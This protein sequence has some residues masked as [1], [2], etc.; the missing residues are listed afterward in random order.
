MAPD[1][2]TRTEELD[3]TS[4]F[5]QLIGSES[6]FTLNLTGQYAYEIVYATIPNDTDEESQTLKNKAQFNGKSVEKSSTISYGKR[7]DKLGA[8]QA[9]GTTDWTIVVNANERNLPIGR[10]VTDTWSSGHILEAGSFKINNSTVI[11]AGFSV[12]HSTTGFELTLTQPTSEEFTITYTT[13]LADVNGII[14]S[15]IP[16]MNTVFRDDR[17]TDTKTIEIA[18]N[19]QVI[20]KT[21]SEPNYAS[22]TI[23][24]TIELNT[25]GYDM[26]NITLDDTFVNSNLKIQENTFKVMRGTVELSSGE[27]YTFT[28]KADKGGFTL[29]IPNSTNRTEKII[30]TYTTD[31]DIRDISNPS[32]QDYLNTGQLQWYT[33]GT[34]YTSAAISRTAEINSQ[35][36]ANGYKEGVYNYEDKKFYWQVGINYNFDTIDTPSFTD[37]LSSSQVVDRA[38]IKI[39]PLDLTGGG[40]GSIEGATALSE[41]SDYTLTEAPLANTFTISFN[42]PITIPYRIVYESA[43]KY[44]YYEP[45]DTKTNHV[46]ENEAVLYKNGSLHSSW[47]ADDITVAHSNTLLTK[48]VQQVG[49]SGTSGSAKLNWSLN[50]NWGQSAIINPV[51]TDTVGKDSEGNPN[52]MIYKDSFAIYEMNFTGENSAPVKGNKHLPGEGLYDITFHEEPTEPTFTIRF[53]QNIDKAYVIEYS[54]YYLGADNTTLENSAILSYG[55][56][57]ENETTESGNSLSG[58]YSANF[59]YFGGASATKGQLQITKEDEETQAPLSGAIFE[60]WNTE[61]GVVIETVSTDENGVYTFKTKVGQGTYFLKETKAPKGYSLDASDY[62]EGKPV[63]IRDKGSDKTPNYV[64]E[65]T[66]GNAKIKQ[67]ILLTK[68]DS[69]D[70][71][72]KLSGA[73]FK[74]QNSSGLPITH[75]VDN[76]LLPAT[77]VTDSEGVILIEN[78]PSGSYQMV[79]V[80]P[81]MGYWLDTTPVDY[82]IVEGQL[83]PTSK[84]ITNTRIGELRIKKVDADTQAPLSGAEFKLYDAG[85]NEVAEA[86]TDST[87]IGRFAGIRYGTYTL[88]ETKAPNGY[89]LESG[90]SAVVGVE[91]T[92]N[93]SLVNLTGTPYENKRILNAF[94]LIKRDEDTNGFLEGAEYSLYYKNTLSQYEIA[95][96]EEGKEFTGLTTNENGEIQIGNLEAGEYRLIETKAPEFY[97]LDTTGHDF[98]I[99]DKQTVFT[100]INATNKRGEGNL[101]ITKVDEADNTI[102]ISDTE[103]QLLDADNSV[104][105]TVTTVDGMVTFNN[106]PY[107]KY[108]LVEIRAHADYILDNTSVE[109]IFDSEEQIDNDSKEITIT[110]KKVDRSIILVKYNDNK[111]IKLKDA[112]FELRKAT[113]SVD[114]NGEEIYQVVD[115][116][117]ISMLTTDNLGEIHLRDLEVGKY[118]LIETKA[119]IGYILEQTPIHFEIIEKQEAPIQLEKVNNRQPVGGIIYPNIPIVPEEVFPEEPTNPEE[120]TK[121]EK[122]VDPESPKESEESEKPKK[123][124]N[125]VTTPKNTPIDITS[126]IPKG[127]TPVIVKQP[128]KGKVTISNKG[129]LIYTPNSNYVGED[130][131]TIKVTHSD[132]TEEE[133]VILIQVEGSQRGSNATIETNSKNNAATLPKTGESR[134]ILLYLTGV[135]LILLGLGIRKKS[136]KIKI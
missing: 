24:W 33:N 11:P 94:Q 13:K 105:D 89:L 95:T 107:G 49:G 136:D 127:K 117:D 23:D 67:S 4:S 16:I 114:E 40:N 125:K 37:T 126:K 8:K 87:G 91:V 116:I 29:A 96:N 70:N 21:N 56:H 135:F 103:F 79:E 69:A 108:S 59:R 1:G 26:E 17:P 128:Q 81:P 47:E 61:N 71:S 102:R 86:I 43:T 76:N 84:V 115:G 42:S 90:S 92:I 73:V 5:T 110:N 6:S 119:P 35:Q 55:Y 99:A 93:S 52:Q 123:E 63:E 120:S 83:E 48:L 39:Y 113:G 15:N 129:K 101:V 97:I 51:I 68:V 109:V 10:K 7:L 77:F 133:L 38:S 44:D 74:L 118:Q 14:S 80:T 100:I 2:I 31:Y 65:V 75:D 112:T 60:L 12:S 57:S 28:K 46:I 72:I 78:L 36:K 131:V 122:P 130:K 82:Q 50:L 62:K 124:S 20:S 66:I 58:I 53:N 111:M 104:V 88:K 134:P 3:V 34:L 85:H 25:A 22:K 54:T 98:V 106:I 30:I 19:Q 41:G 32:T 45:N 64:E 132:G 9:D 18:Y 27:D 121:P